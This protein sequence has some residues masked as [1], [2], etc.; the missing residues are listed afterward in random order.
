[1]EYGKH[2]IG[3]TYQVTRGGG[4][5]SGNS[6]NLPLISYVSDVLLWLVHCRK[7]SK[8]TLPRVLIGNV[9]E[10]W[11]QRFGNLWSTLSFSKPSQ[12]TCFALQLRKCD[13]RREET[14][15]HCPSRV[16]ISSAVTTFAIHETQL[17][18]A[19]SAFRNTLGVLIFY[20]FLSFLTSHPHNSSSPN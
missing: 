14:L 18:M 5:A 7:E 20:L 8:T 3:Q 9:L 2:G 1:M 19:V 17:Y 16:I 10:A 13:G 6:R 11:Y 12:M 4:T 15:S